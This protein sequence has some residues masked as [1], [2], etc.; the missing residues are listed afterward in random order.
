MKNQKT[1]SKAEAQQ[2]DCSRA[3]SKAVRSSKKNTSDNSRNTMRAV[4]LSAMASSALSPAILSPAMAQQAAPPAPTLQLADS[5]SVIATTSE[6][7]PV[8]NISTPNAQGVSHNVF[9]AF[10]TGVEGLILN[11]ATAKGR[12]EIGGTMGANPNLAGKTAAR[13]I[14]NEVTGGI[15]TRLAG[16][17]EVFGNAAGLIIANPTG[18]TCD[19]CGF[20]NAPRVSLAAANVQFGPEGAFSGFTPSGGNVVIEGKGLL[21]GNVDFFDIIASST[22]INASIHAKDLLIASGNATF[23]YAARTATSAANNGG[24]TAG[25]AVDSSALGGMYANKI[26]II[27][28]GAGV[29]VNLSGIVATLDGPLDISADGAVRLTN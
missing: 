7:T 2:T 5:Q 27:G 23:N 21:A 12:S 29:G 10:S 24:T 6:G 1:F 4:L 16:P 26:R 8:V 17:I 15:R 22:L 20:I 9:T 25:V 13:L 14:V 18:I 28:S 19:G 11:N 3:Y